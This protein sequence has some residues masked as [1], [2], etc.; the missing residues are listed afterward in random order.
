MRCAILLTTLVSAIG[1]GSTTNTSHRPKVVQVDV[2]HE[3]ETLFATY[4]EEYLRLNPHVAQA[5]GDTR[6]QHVFFDDLDPEYRAQSKTLAQDSLQRA[7]SISA[8]SLSPREQVAR[9]LFLY[10]QERKLAELDSIEHLLPVNQFYSQAIRF[11]Q[12]GSGEGNHPFH[13]ETDYRDFISQS[14]GFSKWADRAIAAM[15]AGMSKGV[16]L[17]QILVERTLPQ[18]AA[19]AQ[20]KVLDSLFYTPLRA[21]PE[22]LASDKATL[23]RKDYT[24]TISKIIM[25]AYARLHEFMRDQYLPRGISQSGLGALPGGDA[26]YTH[27]IRLHTTTELDADAIHQ[28]GLDEVAR[29]LSEMNEVRRE[30]NFSGDLKAFFAHLS[31]DSKFSFASL[32][33][34]I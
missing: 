7:T 31:S 33:R 25:P 19:H 34:K 29:I 17:P 20:G 30:V 8:R 4:F 18:L 13:T 15:K 26:Y 14:R 23:L 10:L 27:L 21:L 11:A 28:I 16:V 3:L 9:E 5:I 6:Y 1:C 22:E 12:L 32:A 24:E 2:S